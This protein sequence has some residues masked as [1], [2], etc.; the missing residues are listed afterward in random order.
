MAGEPWEEFGGTWLADW[1]AG[2]VGTGEPGWLIGW[3]AGRLLKVKTPR[4]RPGGT[5]E[6]GSPEPRKVTPRKP[7][8]R[9]D[10]GQTEP[11]A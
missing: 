4:Q 5:A 8:S 1:L 7:G 2:A 10:V 6:R 3:L 9:S 11:P